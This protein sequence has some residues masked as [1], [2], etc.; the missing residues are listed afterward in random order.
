MSQSCAQIRNLPVHSHM[1]H[2]VKINILTGHDKIVNLPFILKIIFHCK[3][4][5]KPCILKTYSVNY[6]IIII[7][8]IIII[9]GFLINMQVQGQYPQQWALFQVTGLLHTWQIS[10]QISR[11]LY[12]EGQ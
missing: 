11:C 7:I 10:H 6:E 1:T 9:I 3:F 5:E 8:I 2:M 12:H 4:I